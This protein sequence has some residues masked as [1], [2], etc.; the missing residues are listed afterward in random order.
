MHVMRRKLAAFAGVLTVLLALCGL[1]ATPASATSLTDKAA[2]VWVHNSVFVDPSAKAA[3]PP[4]AANQLNALIRGSGKNVFLAVLSPSQVNAVSSTGLLDAMHNSLGA[5]TAEIIGIVTTRGLYAHAYNLPGS[6][7]TGTV[8]TT[9]QISSHAQ[10]GSSPMTIGSTWAGAMIK[11]PGWTLAGT[12]PIRSVP[13]SSKVNSA[14]VLIVVGVI[15]GLIV[16]GLVI[17]FVIRSKRLKRERAEA[18]AQ[19]TQTYQRHLERTITLSNEL[20]AIEV[21]AELD[22][23]AKTYY[24]AARANL[25]SA[26]TMLERGDF[27]EVANY[28]AMAKDNIT[29]TKRAIDPESAADSQYASRSG[30]GS[31]T[32]NTPAASATVQHEP[33]PTSTQATSTSS[34]SGA[35]STGGVQFRDPQTQQ[36]VVIDNTPR[37]FYSVR[38]PYEFGGGYIGGTYFAAGF[39]PYEFWGAGWG[40]P[41]TNLIVAEE[42]REERREAYEAGVVTGAFEAA[43]TAGYGNTAYVDPASAEPAYVA[44]VDPALTGGG[45]FGGVSAAAVDSGPDYDDSP[46][47]TGGGE[48][49]QPDVS[50]QSQDYAQPDAYQDTSYGDTGGDDFGSNYDT[51]GG[52]D[53]GYDSSGGSDNSGGGDF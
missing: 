22:H 23:T 21:D 20:D 33:A 37:S 48:Y 38:H 51:G 12:T 41:L 49:G 27:T 43:S 30:T 14:V 11:L 3:M 35:S 19:K 47:F 4:A 26:A 44:D 15:V 7:T 53:G 52:S 45:D 24:A 6:L 50:D 31:S 8:T 42:I 18:E 25:S 17:F 29:K 36:V 40:D 28:L 32:S 5:N 2:Q 13:S 10:P 46:T 34:S 1:T 16:I 39:Y 9:T